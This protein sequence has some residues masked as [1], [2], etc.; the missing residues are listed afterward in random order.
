MPLSDLALL[1][2]ESFMD[3]PHSVNN[4]PTDRDPDDSS[5]VKMEDKTQAP[6]FRPVS[7]GF[8]DFMDY[9]LR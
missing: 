8:S 5:G 1:P 6:E 9:G 4:F 2:S 7:K 3:V